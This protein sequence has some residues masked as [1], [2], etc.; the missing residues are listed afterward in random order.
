MAT[1]SLQ[2]WLFLETVALKKQMLCCS[3]S[4]KSRKLVEIGPVQGWEACMDCGGL[5]GR[6]SYKASPTSW[7]EGAE[8]PKGR[9][10]FLCWSKTLK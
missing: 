8:Q 1:F 5:S 3:Y 2:P 10:C 7:K 9:G 4:D 6:K